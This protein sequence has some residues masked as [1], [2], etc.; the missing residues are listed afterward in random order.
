GRLDDLHAG[1]QDTA[2]E[3]VLDHGR[4]DAVLDRVEGI[5]AL[6]FYGHGGGEPGG[7]PIQPDE[8][9]VA[10]GL[11]D[12]VIDFSAHAGARCKPRAGRAPQ[13][14]SRSSARASRTASTRPPACSAYWSATIGLP[15][16]MRATA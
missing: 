1:T 3:R 2:C 12:V 10:E 9:R 4:A 5:E 6:V 15:P 8:R 7:E 16:S 13:R 11:G 14:I